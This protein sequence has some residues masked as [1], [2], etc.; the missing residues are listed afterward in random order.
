MFINN[1]NDDG[2][3]IACKSDFLL[4]VLQKS[5]DLNTKI[6]IE[7]PITNKPEKIH[8]LIDTKNIMVAFNRRHYESVK[9]LKKIIDNNTGTKYFGN[10]QIPENIVGEKISRKNHLNKL[11]NNGIHNIDLVNYLFGKVYI[12]NISYQN[13]NLSIYSFTLYNSKCH[14]EVTSISN[15]IQNTQFD[16]YTNKSR[17]QLLPIEKLNIYDKLEIQEPTNSFPLRSYKPRLSKSYMEKNILFKPGFLRQAEIFYDFIK[18]NT[19]STPPRIEDAYNAL[20]ILNK[21]G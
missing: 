13:L 1:F 11:I 16:I 5:I 2:L 10:L 20:V 9:S 4:P 6:L 14:I 3:V 21:L 17:Y 18:N 7:K 15:A 19:R 8:N 12:K